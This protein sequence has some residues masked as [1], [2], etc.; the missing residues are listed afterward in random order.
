MMRLF[1]ME[2]YLTRGLARMY[3]YDI[4]STPPFAMVQGYAFAEMWNEENMVMDTTYLSGVEVSI[5]NENGYFS[6]H[7]NESGRF[8]LRT[9]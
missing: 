4:Q 8:M 6:V 2:V 7:T 3:N 9:C 1:W 5:Y